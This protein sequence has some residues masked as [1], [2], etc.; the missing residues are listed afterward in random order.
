[1]SNPLSF[2]LSSYVA[3]LGLVVSLLYTLV[4]TFVS[5]V[6]VSATVMECSMV[7]LDGL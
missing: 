2:V 3:V 4:L 1:M 5:C 6:V 7:A